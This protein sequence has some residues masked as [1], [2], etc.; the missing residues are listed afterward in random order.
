MEVPEVPG[1]PQKP[2]SVAGCHMHSLCYVGTLATIT[3]LPTPI[4]E[5]PC[6]VRRRSMN[7]SSSDDFLRRGIKSASASCPRQTRRSGSLPKSPLTI[8]VRPS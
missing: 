8:A 1:L 4:L 6:P 2:H 7:I 5:D 3:V